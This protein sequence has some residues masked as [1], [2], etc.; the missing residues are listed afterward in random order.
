MPGLCGRGMGRWPIEFPASSDL[1]AAGCSYAR[2]RRNE[3]SWCLWMVGVRKHL[4]LSIAPI[5]RLAFPG[6]PSARKGPLRP[7]V[8]CA[9]PE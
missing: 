1:P 5:R 9:G 2:D 3:T 4:L 7:G 6:A 8:M